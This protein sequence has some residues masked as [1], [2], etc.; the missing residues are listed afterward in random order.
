MRLGLLAHKANVVNVA[1]L[2]LQEPLAL[3]EHKD[4]K[5]FKEKEVEQAVMECYLALLQHRNCSF[6]S[7]L[8]SERTLR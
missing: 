7:C 2:V 6:L 8:D 4:H 5:D 1:K 3:L